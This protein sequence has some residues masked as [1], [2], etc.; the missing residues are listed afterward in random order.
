MKIKVGD[1]EVQ[2]DRETK[3]ALDLEIILL[4]FIVYAVI[5]TY[6]YG[7]ISWPVFY[8]LF[9]F[10]YMRFFM[11]NHDRFHADHSKRLPR[12]L[13]LFAEYLAVAVTPWDEPYDSIKKKHFTHHVTHLPKK[14]PSH[15]ILSDP[16]S[17][18]EARGMWRSLFYCLF[19][20]EAQL[21]IDIRNRNI[22]RSRWIRLLLYL[23]LQIVFFLTF[24]WEK[25]LGVFLAVRIMSSS[26]WFFF[27][28]YSHT[29]FYRFGSRKEIPGIIL[30][31]LKFVNG[32]RVGDGFFRHTTHHVWPQVPSGQLYK[33]DEAVLDNPQAKPEMFA[34][35]SEP[36]I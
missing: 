10:F 26:G 19:Y 31:L 13:E 23:P 22:T 36:T 27:S 20:E 5:F 30:F 17:I 7:Y 33:L 16:H 6:A 1:S 28:W 3:R 4:L 8:L 25:Y 2:I 24:G 15:E 14:N 32:K 29:Y 21:V 12:L 11:G 34:T 9:H 18:Y 35:V